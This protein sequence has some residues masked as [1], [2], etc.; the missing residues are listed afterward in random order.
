MAKKQLI[1]FV[2]LPGLCFSQPAKTKFQQMLDF[3]Y[4]DVLRL[5]PTTATFKGDDRYNDQIENPISANYRMN[6]LSLLKRYTDSLRHYDF[7]KLSDKDQL[8]YRIFEYELQNKLEGT[9]YDTYLTPVSQMNDF[10]ISFSQ[11]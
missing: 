9:K 11:M 8:S 4:E 6:S 7:A 1:I 2:I 3:Y 5:N 10:R